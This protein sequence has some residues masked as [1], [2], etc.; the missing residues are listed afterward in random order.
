MSNLY[1]IAVYGA[2][3]A[4]Y[5]AATALAKS[6]WQVILLDVPSAYSEQIEPSNADWIPADTFDVCPFLRRI[7]AAVVERPFRTVQ[8]YSTDLILKSIIV[9]G[10]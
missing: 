4:G 2:S 6:G 3:V 9:Q 5:V 8:F 7:R 10:Q 1:D